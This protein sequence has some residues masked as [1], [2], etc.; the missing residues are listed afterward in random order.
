M[1]H[2]IINNFVEY[3][4]CVLEKSKIFRCDKIGRL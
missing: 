3:C 2:Y 1:C 4:R